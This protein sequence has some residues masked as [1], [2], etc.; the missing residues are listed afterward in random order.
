MKRHEL[1]HRIP[2]P[3]LTLSF[4]APPRRGR[5]MHTFTGQPYWPCDPRPEE[6]RIV[7]IAHHLSMLCR[8]TGAVKRFYSVAEHCVLVS[9]LVPPEH[10]LVGLLHDAPEAYLGDINRPVKHG[11]G[12]EGFR[13]LEHRNWLA[14]A[15]RFGLPHELPHEVEMAD[16]GVCLIERELLFPPADG[17]NE[18]W[19]AVTPHPRIGDVAVHALSPEH[20]EIVFLD[21]FYEV[22]RRR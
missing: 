21:R 7:D 8:Y 14:V 20:A 19:Q 16:N 11:P 15:D 10:A 2:E 18:E 22:S 1:L 17:W 13:E 6:V 9:Y 12:L 3:N 4:D 5:F